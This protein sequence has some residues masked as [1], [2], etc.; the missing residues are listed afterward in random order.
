M[1]T[2][3]SLPKSILFFPNI[4]ITD[5]SSLLFK[6]LEQISHPEFNTLI[7]LYS[8]VLA[9]SL[10]LKINIVLV[11]LKVSESFCKI[12]CYLHKLTLLFRVVVTTCFILNKHQ[13]LSS[14][15]QIK[16]S[17]K[18]NSPLCQFLQPENIKS[19]SDFRIME[20]T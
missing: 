5:R 15:T 16:V 8:T 9:L 20:I 19:D 10:F 17:F 6:T 7:S 11:I 14:N 2:L 1:C 18:T 12:T 13:R 4:F 3:A